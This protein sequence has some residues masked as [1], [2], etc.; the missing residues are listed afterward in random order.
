LLLQKRDL[1]IVVSGR[2]MQLECARTKVGARLIFKSSNTS[3]AFETHDCL[4]PTF[5]RPETV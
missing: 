2:E 1:S 5:N 4:R 3:A